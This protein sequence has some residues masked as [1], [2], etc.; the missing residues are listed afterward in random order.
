MSSA[1]ILAAWNV[2]GLSRTQC[3]VLMALSDFCSEKTGQCNPSTQTLAEHPNVSMTRRGVNKVLKGLREIGLIFPVGRRRRDGLLSSNHW[4]LVFLGCDL[5]RNWAEKDAERRSVKKPKGAADDTKTKGTTVPDTQ[6]TKGTAVPDSAVFLCQKGTE[7]L[8]AKGTPVHNSEHL[9]KE[10]SSEQDQERGQ[11]ASAAPSPRSPQA[12]LSQVKG[13]PSAGRV[14]TRSK[15]QTYDPF[16]EPLPDWLNLKAFGEWVDHR[17]SLRKPIAC[18]AQALKITEQFRDLDQQQQQSMVN[19][20]ITGGYPQVY[21]DR[22]SSNVNQA[23]LG[24]IGRAH[25]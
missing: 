11:T 10:R 15:P 21:P 2:P 19:Y 7:V 20:S 9:L 18:R 16:A 6:S 3:A 12:H 4:V 23:N 17:A 13:Q 24:K 14:K 1:A 8:T 22:V 5:N 25:V